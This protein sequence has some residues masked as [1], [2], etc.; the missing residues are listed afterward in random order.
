MTPD[1]IAETVV[2]CVAGLAL[3]GA[4]IAR[5][6]VKR[7]WVRFSLSVAVV[8]LEKRGQAPG[9]TTETAPVPIGAGRE[10]DAA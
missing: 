10:R 4:L 2:G 6:F 1:G 5:E 8:P 3:I 7:G 9:A